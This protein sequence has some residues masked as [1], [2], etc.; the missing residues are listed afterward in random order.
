MEV[1]IPQMMLSRVNIAI[2]V[3][4]GTAFAVPRLCTA[5][6]RGRLP[7]AVNRIERETG[8]KVLSAERSSHNGR[9]ATRVKVYTPDGRVRVM[10]DK[11]PHAQQPQPHAQPRL[12]PDVLRMPAGM[13]RPS[14]QR[15]QAQVM[16]AP[17]APAP[18]PPSR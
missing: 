15:G 10:W 11:P 16:Q 12:N 6:E 14:A 9:E 3:L 5:E 18:A 8:G 1:K 13:L 4:A 17:P 2:V 7:D